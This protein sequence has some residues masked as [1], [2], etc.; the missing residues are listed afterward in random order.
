MER[1]ILYNKEGNPVRDMDGGE[2]I[3][4]NISYDDTWMGE[5]FITIDIMSSSPVDFSIGDYVMYRGERFEV[6][7]DPG[8]IKTSSRLSAGDAFKY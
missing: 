6:N 7:Y 8:K 5:C 2:V 1:L 4:D 3:I